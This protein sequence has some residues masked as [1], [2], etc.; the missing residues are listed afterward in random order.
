MKL[1]GSK[2]AVL[3][4][5]FMAMLIVSFVLGSTLVGINSYA[6]SEE[7]DS[8]LVSFA[9]IG[10]VSD[11]G[12][13][14]SHDQGRLAVEKAFKGKVRTSM[15]ENLP[16]SA[17]ASR[18][19]EQFIANGA[20]MIFVS[21]TVADFTAN[22]AKKHPEIAF[23]EAGG[24]VQSENE[25]Q[26]Y[27]AHWD[28]SY[29]IGMAAGLLTETNKLGYVGSFAVSNV[30]SSV[31]SFTLGAQSVNP[32]ITTKVVLINSWFDPSKATQAANTLIDYGADFLF[33][34]M[35]EAAYLQVAE[36]RGVWAAM[37]NTDIRRFGPEAYVTSVLLDWNDFY[38]SEVKAM[39]DGT[40]TGDRLVILPIGKGVDRDAWGKN[41]PAEV[42]RK[43][44]KVRDKM[45]CEGYNP[46]VGPIKDSK[47]KVRIPAGQAMTISDFYG[48][49]WAVEGVSG[50][51]E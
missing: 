18:L 29:L 6:E 33:G 7:S 27:V 30:Y 40:W 1:A 14:W 46:F 42:Q 48:W 22:V 26:Y 3:S 37:W 32:N 13:T 15:V 34:I 35:D 47:G 16:Y 2:I 11:E 4:R 9:H 23:M 20:R 10:P 39:L 43:V 28:V 51:P 50:M 38:V 25:G 8:T 41:V 5:P 44:D 31:N 19:L 12:W 17:E 24:F 36:K 45:V 49:D 21:S